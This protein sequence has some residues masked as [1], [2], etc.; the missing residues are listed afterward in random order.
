MEVYVHIEVQMKREG[1]RG[2]EKDREKGRRTTMRREE[3][4]GGEKDEDMERR[5]GSRRK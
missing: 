4:G 1:Q 5:T 3:H 2:V